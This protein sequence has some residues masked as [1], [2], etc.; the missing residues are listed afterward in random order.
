MEFKKGLLIHSYNC[1]EP[2][3]LHTVWG[4]VPDKP[5]RAV[6]AVKIILEEKIDV[7]LICGTAGEKDGKKESWWLKDL[8]YRNLEELKSFTVYPV[9]QEYTAEEIRQILDRVLVIKE[10]DTG[11][12]TAGEAE[13]AGRFFTEAGVNRVFT[14]SSPDHVSR[15]IRDVLIQWRE[16]YPLL[17]ANTLTSASWTL[18]SE[19]TPE[20][21]DIAKLSNV[22]IAEPPVVRTFN[23]GRLFKILKNPGAL[24]EVD[25]VLKKNSA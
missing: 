22:I 18:Y 11:A 19:R 6:T 10:K 24:A 14:I 20:D 23:L 8:I 12:N 3:W 21:K 7:A 13:Y 2:N 15:C 25:A 1:L 16:K 4:F 5:G 9:F 17:A